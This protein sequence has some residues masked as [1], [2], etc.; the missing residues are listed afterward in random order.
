MTEAATPHPRS[1]RLRSDE[2]RTGLD[3]AWA[4]RDRLHTLL[5]AV[6]S[7]GGDLDVETVLQ[8]IVESAVILVDA[9][10]GALGVIGDEEQLARFLTVGDDATIEG[11]GDRPS[12]RGILGFV[13][14]EP[15]PLRLRDLNTHPNA[16][17]FPPGHPPMRTFLGVPIRTRKKVFGNI[18]LTEKR[19]GADFT[20]EDDALLRTLAAAAGVVIDNARLNDEARHREQWMS[21]GS[22]LTRNL[23][24]GTHPGQVLSTFAATV[25]S[26]ASADLVM[27]VAP[28]TGAAELV[29]TAADGD[30]VEQ[31]LGVVLPA[32]ST[33]TKKMYSSGEV[34]VSPDI[35]ADPQAEGSMIASLGLGPTFMVPLGG[36]G[37]IRG[38]L[39]VANNA[40]GTEFADSV[41]RTVARFAD[42]AA[43]AL[44][45]AE[46]RWEAEL[47]TV[48]QDRDR[49]ARDLHDLAIQRLFATG[50]MLQS[51]TRLITDTE[52]SRRVE[53]AV[54]DLDETIKVIRTTIF[55]LKVRDRAG[56]PGLR[57]RILDEM[58]QAATTLGFGPSLRLDGLLDTLVPADIA[59]SAIAVLREALSNITRHAAAGRVEISAEIVADVLHLRVT[60]NGIGIPDKPTRRSGL[61][62]MYERA[63]ALSGDFTV[64]RRPGGGTTLSWVAPLPASP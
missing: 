40:G 12:G 2:S 8:R 28:V 33:L 27:V 43:L 3:G 34:F 53:R 57:A 19:G 23:L 29:V 44:E 24:A 60:D 58:D 9:E 1:P 5:E 50:M 52:A 25:R 45:I 15:H 59:D 47:L 6:L 31:V 10:Y 32:K 38:I 63:R 64:M 46:R 35:R 22:E 62:N 51:A 26:M 13:V 49:I 42:H 20:D 39:Q 11:I 36:P 18:Y 37:H 16:H 17:G 7:V 55:S 61:D 48:F 30:R 14:R 56:G 4:T 41:V 21:A 54:D